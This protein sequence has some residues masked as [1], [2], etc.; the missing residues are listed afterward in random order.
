MAFCLAQPVGGLLVEKIE[1]SLLCNAETTVGP[2]E[3]NFQGQG[4]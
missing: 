3:L 1:V 4:I 2:H